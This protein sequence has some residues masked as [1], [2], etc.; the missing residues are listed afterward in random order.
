MSRKKC[1]FVMFS[2]VLTRE[3]M[4]NQAGYYSILAFVLLIIFVAL[5]F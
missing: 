2:G 4:E 1:K 5:L 3:R